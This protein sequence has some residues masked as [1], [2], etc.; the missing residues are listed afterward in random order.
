MRPPPIVVVLNQELGEP[1]RQ[2]AMKA[3]SVVAGVCEAD[4]MR[5]SFGSSLGVQLFSRIMVQFQ[6]TQCAKQEQNGS[7]RRRSFPPH[8]WKHSRALRAVLAT[9][10]QRCTGGA[11]C[12]Q[13]NSTP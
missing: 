5:R 1:C 9:M 6:G 8:N 4:M 12:G 2:D 7:E 11:A 3:P 13:W 10:G